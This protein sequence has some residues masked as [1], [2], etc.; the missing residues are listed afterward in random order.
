MADFAIFACCGFV[1]FMLALLAGFYLLSIY[2]GLVQLRNNID[3]A[4]ANIDV[5]L[6]QRTDLI[7]NLVEAVKGYMKHEKSTLEE[8]TRLRTAM[9]SAS[10]PAEK[11]RAS[12]GISAALKTIFAVAENY[13][14]LEASQNFLKLQEQLTA[15][16]NQI[17]D[18]REFYND[19]VMLFNTRIHS[20]PD[21][22]FASAM[23]Y[24]DKEYFKAAEGEK[25]AV[26]VKM[27]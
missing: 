6:K 20:L 17:A 24:R 27:E 4:W 2:N 1:V 8:I 11:A 12:E 21:S 14:K 18:R 22:L 25:G 5:V 3:K 15:M 16:E 7:P 26:S 10:G 19:S 13:P 23:G 9:M